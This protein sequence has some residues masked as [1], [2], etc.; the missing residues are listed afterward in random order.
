MK[1]LPVA[2]AVC[3][4]VAA[5]GCMEGQLRNKTVSLSTTSSDLFYIQVLDNLARTIDCP[6]DTPYFDA[7]AAGTAQIQQSL[8]ITGT[9]QWGLITMGALAGAFVFNQVSGAF[10]PQQID[11]ESWQVAPVA[12]PDRLVLMHSAYLKVTGHDSPEVESLLREYYGARDG[13]VDISIQ[14]VHYSNSV[15]DAWRTLIARQNEILGSIPPWDHLTEEQ[16]GL[17]KCKLWKAP[18][19]VVSQPVQPIDLSSCV[20]DGDDAKNKAKE[21]YELAMCK[22]RQDLDA[23][24]RNFESRARAE[25]ANQLD[26]RPELPSDPDLIKGQYLSLALKYELARD[27]AF[28]CAKAKYDILVPAPVPVVVP[29]SGG[30][31]SY[32]AGASGGSGGGGGGGSSSPGGSAGGA[33]TKPP[34]PIHVPYEEFLRNGWY[35]VGQRRDVPR[36]ACYVGHHCDTYVWVMPDQLEGLNNF[37]LAILD[38]Y[39]IGNS[40]GSNIPQPPPATLGR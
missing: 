6:A 17:C 13:W 24:N 28:Q 32:G 26:L 30:A 23:Y 19:C 20:K 18:Y 36:A 33:G 9:P 1:I 34:L 15:W 3:L 10:T 35:C 12:D 29:N 21:A 7:P 25:R 4:L 37:T 22:Y 5:G 40:G 11:Q 31:N 14:Q 16:K 27:Q 8:S 2:V 39:N 38:F